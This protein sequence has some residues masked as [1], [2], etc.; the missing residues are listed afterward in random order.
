MNSTNNIKPEIDSWVVAEE[1]PVSAS[2]KVIRI[3]D[4]D[5]G[6]TEDEIQERNEFIRWYLMQDFKPLM[7]IPEQMPE[8]DFFFHDCTVKDSEY[9]AFNTHDFQKTSRPFNK[10]GFAMKKIMERVKDL[11]ILHSVISSHERR[12]ETYQRYEALVELEFRNR[13]KWLVRRYQNTDDEET[14]FS[15]KQKIGETNRRII[16]CRKT[17]EQYA[18]WGT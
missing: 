9:S 11:A 17:W 6:L 1:L 16:E 4:P 12:H 13:L 2:L 7:T 14:R 5:Y 18:P 8:N 15:L 10:Y 3:N